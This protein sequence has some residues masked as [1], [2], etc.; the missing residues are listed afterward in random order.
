M[1]Y[2]K[3][4]VQLGVVGLLASCFI[5]MTNAAG[6]CESQLIVA[7]KKGAQTDYTAQQLEGSFNGLS[8]GINDLGATTAGCWSA[9][10]FFNFISAPDPT[11]SASFTGI[12]NDTGGSAPFQSDFGGPFDMLLNGTLEMSATGTSQL[13]LG[14]L[15]EDNNYLLLQYDN[16]T[17]QPDDNRL[18]LTIA[19]R[20]G[21]GAF[22]NSALSGSFAIRLMLLYDFHTNN[23]EA[24]TG[25]GTISFDGQSTYQ[26][27]Y[28]NEGGNTENDDGTSTGAYTVNS[29]GSVILYDE[30]G[31][32]MVEGRLST[33]SNV[34]I[35]T[36]ALEGNPSILF[37][38]FK[39]ADE[40][41]PYTTADLLGDYSHAGLWVDG[42]T[43]G[44][45]SDQVGNYNYGTISFDGRGGFTAADNLFSS[46]GN[47][48]TNTFEGAYTIT[49]EGEVQLTTTTKN[50]QAQQ[51]D[52]YFTG[53]LS[54]DRQFLV[55][56]LMGR[57]NVNAA[58]DGTD[59]GMDTET[60][61]DGKDETG[62]DSSGGCFV[63]TFN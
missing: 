15:S 63:N 58:N 52:D 41:S 24:A 28:W 26:L 34:F 56:N 45:T 49:P 2:G 47:T 55:F 16:A 3:R 54:S 22:D 48:E 4:S 51:E 43:A 7:V 19:A 39:A 36:N 11:W 57:E 13:V 44:N 5:A 59:T 46:A 6:F 37:F 31:R 8:Y 25:R 33:E 1:T 40:D 32:S 29:D 23:K 10:G 50:G 30:Q 61:S 27:E 62:E 12:Y 21:A 38:G 42:L 35:L 18:R 14:Q 60:P 20:K 17:R 53:H 9:E